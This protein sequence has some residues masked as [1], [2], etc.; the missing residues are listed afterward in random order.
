M[1]P[2]LEAQ[3][4]WQGF[5]ARLTTYIGDHIAERLPED[6]IARIEEQVRL[7]A[8]DE[9]TEVIRP[10]VLVARQRDSLR[11]SEAHAGISTL[12]PVAV[13]FPKTHPEFIRQ[14]RVEI[15]RLP[16]LSLVTVIEVLS[17]DNKSGKG[18]EDYLA[19]RELLLEQAVHLVEIDLLLGG[20]R[21]PMGAALPS[22]DYYAFVARVERWP[23]CDVY[24]WTVRDHLPTIPIPLR[25]PDPD[26]SL[27]LASPVRTAYDRGLYGR[28][29][30]YHVALPLPLDDES[31]VWAE[32]V[33]RR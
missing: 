33:G 21:L 22:G 32:G 16:E 1:D 11:P 3:S 28:T 27:D 9:E 17:P 2:Y 13:P 31:R 20:R 4:N 12:E 8:P 24:A 18:R 29:T 14:R 5:H 10:D 6:Y 26:V 23:S 19:K 30:D 15:R 25:L 7:E